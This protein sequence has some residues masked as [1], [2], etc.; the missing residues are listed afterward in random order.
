L[1]AVLGPT[2]TGKSALALA[3]A[4]RLD[5]EIV[6]CDALQ[7]YRGF[8][9]A[10]AKPTCEERERVAH[11]LIDHIPPERFYTLA[12]FVREADAAIRE[13]RMRSRLPIVVGGTGMYFRGLMRGILE[14]PPRN[15]KRRTRLLDMAGRF[16]T[17]RLH[18]WLGSL[19]SAS[20]QRV[21]TGDTQ[22]VVRALD[23]ALSGQPNW[24]TRLRQE[25][26]WNSEHERYSALK[27]GLDGDRQWLQD[28]LDRRVERFLAAGLVEE[29]RAL[30]ARGVPREANAFK[31]IGY[32]EVL[33]A[34]P[35]GGSHD[36]LCR[37]IQINT[38]RFSKRQRTWF[39]REAGIAWLDA[40]EPRTRLVEESMRLWAR[41]TKPGA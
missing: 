27:I 22:R 2:G 25:G 6:G 15:A 1:L 41:F 17:P 23:L 20:A 35:E 28:R 36:D 37:E 13:I 5:G 9:T 33:A 7:V 8:D 14:V 34:L 21:A 3:L 10:T 40:A 26:S 11:H 31:A 18:R 4:Q 38:R 19:D 39:R 29:V 24:G 12:E 16:G 30:V 32:R